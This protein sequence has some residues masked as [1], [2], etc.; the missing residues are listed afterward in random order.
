MS[1]SN[2]SA[3]DAARGKRVARRGRPVGDREAKRVELLEAAIS[4]I[5]S[6]GYAGASMRKVANE[7]GCTTGAVTYYFAN[8]EEMVVAIAQSVFDEFDLLLD[9]VGDNAN[10]R[11]M[12]MSWLDWSSMENPGK[13]LALFQLLV[14]A[15]HEPT[16]ASII[17]ERYSRFRE[18][19]AVKLVKGQKDG[20]IRSDI[21]A[22]ILADQ[23][24]AICDGWMMT[25]PLEPERFQGK[26]GKALLD[27]V[28]RL[29]EPVKA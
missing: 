7:A 20:S 3:P 9:V 4:V 13:W 26:R 5:A 15:R 10:I 19:L 12:M 11:A 24:A 14:H 23:I 2:G 8:K 6:D 18:E 17:R 22:G 16:F 21:E 29:L 28:V 1:K 25:M 27:S